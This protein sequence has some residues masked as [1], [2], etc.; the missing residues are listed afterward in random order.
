VRNNRKAYWRADTALRNT[1][2]IGANRNREIRRL[3]LLNDGSCASATT[4]STNLSNQKNENSARYTLNEPSQ[5]V[6][7]TNMAVNAADM[8]RN[9]NNDIL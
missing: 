8:G 7:P 4:S 6:A 2:G 9:R 3:R 5:G 1:Y